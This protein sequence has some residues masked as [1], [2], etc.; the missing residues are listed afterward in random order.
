M[1]N[2][3]KTKS[4][5]QPIRYSPQY[6]TAVF[7][8]L[9]TILFLMWGF[10]NE[11]TF[12]LF[13]GGTA[14][15][16]MTVYQWVG[17]GLAVFCFTLAVVIQRYGLPRVVHSNLCINGQLVVAGFVFPLLLLEMMLDPFYDVPDKEIS[18]FMKDEQLG[19][20]LI[21]NFEENY[22][23]TP[24]RINS[25]GLRGDELLAP[26]PSHTKRILFLGD[27]VVFGLR[28]ASE[29]KT[30]P[31]MTRRRI[32]EKLGLSVETVNAGVPGYNTYQEYLYFK[33]EGIHVK[34]DTVVLCFVMNDPLN[35]YTQL[36]Y[37]DNG[38]DSPIAYLADTPLNAMLKQSSIV[39][40]VQY[41]KN[42]LRSELNS[43]ES[44]IYEELFSA[45][46]LVERAHHEEIQAAWDITQTYLMKTAALCAEHDIPFLLVIAPYQFQ[47]KE[48][49]GNTVPQE[50]L[51]D[52]AEKNN[53]AFLDLLPSLL[54]YKKE[55]HGDSTHIFQDYCHFTEA[56][57]RI[58]AEQITRM[59]IQHA[60]LE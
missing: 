30:I 18:I 6:I 51:R 1:Q 55:N 3:Q 42:R 32:E 57:N 11:H 14:T 40:A 29:N 15:I 60:M 36:Q 24:I 13:V 16:S 46:S 34:P 58:C 8:Y 50:V 35:T 22:G 43:R 48:P 37:G 25:Q 56:G 10:C 47:F 12:S 49:Q 28:I 31:G 9:Y 44:A 21:P 26:K 39:Q 4:G 2:E 17:A 45:H 54:E 41:W 19:W 33:Q 7:F 53:I 27:S 59:L 52:F 20:R 5:T 38:V 23:E